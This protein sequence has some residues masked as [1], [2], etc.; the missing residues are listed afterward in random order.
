MASPSTNL[1]FILFPLMAQG[2]MIPMVDIAR[3]LAQRGATVT[4]ITTPVNAGRFKSVI[5]RASEAMLKIQVLVLPLATS[6]VG[7]PEGCENFDLLPSAAFSDN[8]FAAIDML[9]EPAEKM[10]RGLSLAPSCIISD[11]GISWTTNVAKRLNIPRIIFFGPG[12][13]TS[14]CINIAMNTNILDEID[15]DFEY[16][17]L[18]GLPDRIEITKPQASG[19]G[20]GK[21]EASFRR[22]ERR[23]EAGKAAYG[24]VVNSFEELE[25]KYVE[26]FTK[27]KDKKV[28]C[29]GPVS[30]CNKSFQD[31]AERGNKAAVDGHDC[32]K[33]LDSRETRSVV[34][35]C[36]GSLSHTSTDQA[37]ELALGLELSNIPFIWFIKCTS[38]K[39]ERWISEG[40]YEDRIK[41]RG[42]IVR[43][44]APQVLIL[45]HQA[46][47]GFITHCGW[48]STLE[49]ISAG[50]PMVTWS[51]FADQ[52]LNERFIIDVLKIGVRIGAEIPVSYGKNDNC[53]VKVKRENIKTAVECL[54][55]NSEEG[56]ARR[57]MAKELGEMAKRAMEDG[58]SSHINMTSM[59]H[60]ITQEL[61]KNTKLVQDL[62]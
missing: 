13:F 54:M 7:L 37:I 20:K 6:E 30:L 5:D 33:W 46:I 15:S 26:A 38:E 19:W 31:T 36:F 18:P 23:Q 22:F 14:L 56:N 43:G 51:H 59:I 32:L 61:G 16:F 52:F 47:G 60:D 17:V 50:I 21:T 48:N 58:G 29:I 39:L 41:D 27:V 40:G 62:A 25:P 10:L 55:N 8:L 42:L 12:C 49:A 4:I 45:S 24:I 1:H 9:E 44:W 11:H 35:V 3:I 53:E 28:W 57:K 34:Y 2:H